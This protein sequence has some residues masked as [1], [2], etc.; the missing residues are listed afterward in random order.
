MKDFKFVFIGLVIFAILFCLIIFLVPTQ[1][2]SIERYDISKD[3]YLLN[4]EREFRINPEQN[5]TCNA[6]R[7][8]SPLL[9]ARDKYLKEN[10]LILKGSWT[11]SNNSAWFTVTTSRNYYKKE[12]E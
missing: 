8:T 1:N 3:S 9:Q 6:T 4:L 12:C 11:F 5:L 10:C 7:C 2:K